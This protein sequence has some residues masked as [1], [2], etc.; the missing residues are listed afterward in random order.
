MPMMITV[1]VVVAH[2]PA[3]ARIQ[4]SQLGEALVGDAMLYNLEI[5]VATYLG[6]VAAAAT[7]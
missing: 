1:A 6:A 4:R 7:C 2:H 3:Q 5:A